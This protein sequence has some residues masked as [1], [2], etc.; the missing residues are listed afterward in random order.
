MPGSLRRSGGPALRPAPPPRPAGAQ[1]PTGLLDQTQLELD[2]SDWGYKAL[3]EEAVRRFEANYLEAL[4]GATGGNVTGAAELAGI[5][6][7]NLHRML[8]KRDARD[9]VN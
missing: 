4:L 8:K 2:G 9:E 1:S 7:V 3:K 5:H 6:R